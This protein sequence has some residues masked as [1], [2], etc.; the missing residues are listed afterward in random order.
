MWSCTAEWLRHRRQINEAKPMLIT[1][2]ESF[3]WRQAR[4][5]VSAPELSSDLNTVNSHLYRSFPKL[6]VTARHQLRDVV[7]QAGMP[8][9]ADQNAED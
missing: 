1:A 2:L 8:S 7:A 5:S 3:R 4:S 6:A 9:A